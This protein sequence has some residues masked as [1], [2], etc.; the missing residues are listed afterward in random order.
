M[1]NELILIPE[2]ATLEGKIYL[3]DGM[4]LFVVFNFEDNDFC[5][6]KDKQGNEMELLISNGSIKDYHWDYIWN[7]IYVHLSDYM[8]WK[9]SELKEAAN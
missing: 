2:K 7:S 8:D 6:F 3:S 1:I 9:K 5:S 4:V